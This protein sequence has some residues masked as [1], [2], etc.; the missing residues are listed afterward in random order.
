MHELYLARCLVITWTL[1]SFTPVGTLPG[2]DLARV[3][4]T[5]FSTSV[6]NFMVEA[7]N[8][9]I[10]SSSDIEKEKVQGSTDIQPG[11]LQE[12]INASGHVQEVDRQ[13]GLWSICSTSLMTDNAWAAGSGAL[14]VALYNG[15]PPGVLYE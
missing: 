10:M 4:N 7:V 3:H 13:F 5:L 12:L 14:T 15:G 1:D 2:Y 6:E 11:D 9:D 8:A